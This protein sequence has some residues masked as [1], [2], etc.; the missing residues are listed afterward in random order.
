MLSKRRQNKMWTSTSQ[1]VGF[2]SLI[3]CKTGLAAHRPSVK[4]QTFNPLR[5]LIVV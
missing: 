2:I 5:T 4:P 3:I 1:M